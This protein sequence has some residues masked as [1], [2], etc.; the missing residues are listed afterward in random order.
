MPGSGYALVTGASGDIGRSIAAALA[1]EGYDL[2]L[3]C[4]NNEAALTSLKDM[5]IKDYDVN[6]KCYKG[7]ISDPVFVREIFKDISTLDVLVNNAG[8]SY[9]GLIQDMTD[10][11]WERVIN[12]NLS[13]VFYTSR[14]ALKLMIRRHAGRI[15]N[16]SSV[17]GE[18]G[19][20]MEA[21]YSA[22]KG[23]VNALTKAL[24]KETAASNISINAISCGFIDT[25]MNSRLSAEEKASIKEDIPADK[26]GTSE[27][28][29]SMVV[30]LINSP[31]YLTGQ[32]I[33][34]DGGWM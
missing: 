11:E 4:F 9:V 20:S 19:G 15:I 3:T 18:F 26:F 30:N 24:A 25:K 22:S 7:D 1:K 23:G 31:L 5:L 34:L 6:I 2:Y 21:A 10:E 14:E 29:S 28:V 13:S 27:D 16:I 33:R 32:I 8:I 12:T 17:F